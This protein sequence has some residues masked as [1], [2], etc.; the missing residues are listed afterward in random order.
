[1]SRR[2]A[3]YLACHRYREIFPTNKNFDEE[4]NGIFVD[5][6]ILNFG[7]CFFNILKVA[8]REKERLAE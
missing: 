4:N 2:T 1:M 5:N 3:A 7:S 6:F 8:K